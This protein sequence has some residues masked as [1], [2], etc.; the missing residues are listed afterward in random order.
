MKRREKIFVLSAGNRKLGYWRTGTHKTETKILQIFS[1]K[2]WTDFLR[3]ETLR[4][5]LSAQSIPKASAL[6]T[7]DSLANQELLENCPIRR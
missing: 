2:F 5:K 3:Q 7:Q 1:V 6:V 4:G